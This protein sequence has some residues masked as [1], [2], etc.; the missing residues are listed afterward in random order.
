MSRS[1][2]LTSPQLSP[3]SSVI[4]VLR[5][6]GLSLRE[7][8]N[9]PGCVP[10]IE[11]KILNMTQNNGAN[12]IHPLKVNRTVEIGP[13]ALGLILATSSSVQRCGSGKTMFGFTTTAVSGTKRDRDHLLD[14]R[15]TGIGVFLSS[16]ASCTLSNNP[17]R[18][19]VKTY[20]VTYAV[21]RRLGE[22]KPFL[23]Y[24]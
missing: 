9:L 21:R 24:R 13:N 17:S 16:V 5:P 4:N 7:I 10:N 3:M 22:Q 18:E 1:Q 23:W 14:Y 19:K 6:R 8:I 15:T 11:G 2:W 12:H 20:W